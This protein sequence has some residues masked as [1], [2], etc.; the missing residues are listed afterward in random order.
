MTVKI[1]LSSSLHRMGLGR[2][3]F[4][5]YMYN[6]MGHKKDN[7]TDIVLTMCSMEKR[8]FNWMKRMSLML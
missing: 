1:K 8:A 5:V 3:I 2:G 6:L 7:K 4:E